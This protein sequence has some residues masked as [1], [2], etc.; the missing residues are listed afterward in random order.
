MLESEGIS[1]KDARAIANY[2]RTSPHAFAKTMI[3]KEL[4]LNMDPGPVHSGAGLIMG[5]SY[6]IASIVPLIA[7]FFFSCHSSWPLSP[8]WFS[9][10][11]VW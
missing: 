7:Y 11:P 10:S 2:L 3:E 1:S 4:G 8:R 9:G 5:L 6:M